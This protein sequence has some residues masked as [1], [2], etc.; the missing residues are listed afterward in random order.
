MAESVV[1]GD[2]CAW[3]TI[4]DMGRVIAHRHHLKQTLLTTAIVGTILFGIIQLD[5]VLGGDAEA[6][7]W[8]KVALTYVVP[9]IV[10]NVGILIATHPPQLRVEAS[11][12]ETEPGHDARAVSDIPWSGGRTS[13]VTTAR[14]A[15]EMASR[16]RL[17]P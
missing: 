5:V 12:P 3:T 16:S 2:E 10:S 13:A 14:P 1:V 11:R 8:A 6:T 9:F 7:V 4:G 17:G 15:A